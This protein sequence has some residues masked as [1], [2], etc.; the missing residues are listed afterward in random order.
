MWRGWNYIDLTWAWSDTSRLSKVVMI[1][2][3]TMMPYK[4]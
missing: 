2:L 1:C 4:D 3:D